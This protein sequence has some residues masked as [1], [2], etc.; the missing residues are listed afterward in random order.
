MSVRRLAPKELQPE[1]F[2]F[3]AENLAWAENTIAKYP[4][5]RQASAVIPLLMRAQEQAGGWVSEPAM[6]Y[7][8]DML[9][10][11]P[12]R[13]YEVATFYT[14]FQL[15]PVGRKA[16]IQVCGTTPCMLKGA[17]DLMKVCKNKIHAEPFH[18]NE[19]GTLSWEEVECAGAC[20][21]A[22]MVQVVNEVFE[23]LTPEILEGIIDAFERGEKPTTGPQN[24]RKSSEPVTGL[25]VLTS[26]E[27]YDGSMVGTG[28]GLAAAREAIAARAAAAAAP[29]P[30]EP[31]A[32]AAP[33][34]P[35]KSDPAPAKPPVAEAVKAAGSA[36]SDKPSKPVAPPPAGEKGN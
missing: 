7:V 5:G 1:S 23:D 14:Q 27:L 13:V 35:P 11:A 9:G 21:N 17:G 26:P 8:G 28:V 6:R 10:M 12:I 31:A 29:K 25:R 18:L 2:A 19:S 20:V 4:A 24:G 33:A 16:H 15:L 30:A 32:A 36:D 34:A 22:P 3:T